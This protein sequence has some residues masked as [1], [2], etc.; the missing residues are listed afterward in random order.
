MPRACCLAAVAAFFASF[1]YVPVAHGAGL[2]V[3]LGGGC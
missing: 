3:L 2:L 1:L